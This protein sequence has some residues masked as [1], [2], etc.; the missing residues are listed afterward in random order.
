MALTIYQGGYGHN[1]RGKIYAYLG[2]AGKR[3]GQSVVAPV[4]QR[5]RDGS[6]GKT[7]NTMFTI[8]RTNS[9]ETE[10]GQNTMETLSGRGIGLKTLPLD[11]SVLE[12]PTGQKWQ[13]LA[14]KRGWNEQQA[15]SMWTLTSNIRND[16]KLGDVGGWVSKTSMLNSLLGIKDKGVTAQE[17]ESA[18]KQILGVLG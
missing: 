6:R 12:L 9:A 5:K 14:Q 16:E 7:Y 4:T 8:M 2:R 15:K 18:R 17:Q 13:E 11:K 10:Y 1:P 3:A